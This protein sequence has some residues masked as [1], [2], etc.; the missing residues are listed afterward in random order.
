M[1]SPSSYFQATNVTASTNN[2]INALLC[3]TKWGG[4]LGSGVSM[5][6]SFNSNQSYY[7]QNY[8]A[9]REY[10]NAYLLNANQQN[11]VKAALQTWANVANLK[12]SQVTDSQAAA[13]DLRFAGYLG[14]TDANAWAYNPFEGAAGGDTWFSEDW[15]YDNDA[16]KGSYAYHTAIHEIGHALGLKHSFDVE[17]TGAT[18]PTST[19]STRYT[20]MSYTHPFDYSPTSPMLYDILA[21]QYLYGKNTSYNSGNTTYSWAAGSK[22]FET[23]WDGG[24]V[25]TISASNQTSAVK[26]N[27]NSGQNSTIGSMINADL[28]NDGYWDNQGVNDLLYIAYGTTIENAV[29]SGYNDTLIGNSV[30]NI[31]NGGGGND[32]MSGGYGNDTYYVNSNGDTV[33]ESAESSMG[34]I[35]TV[36][37][38]T[39][40]TLTLSTWTLGAYQENLIIT[41]AASF[42]GTGNGL[43]NKLTGN[44]S[45][46]I[47]K[48][49]AGND[50]LC[51]AAGNDSLYGGA[52]TDRF[53]LDSLTGYDR[54]ADFSSGSEKVICDN[55]SLGGI[56]D[57][58][59]TLEGIALRS[60]AGGFSKS[61]ELLIFSS[62]ISGSISQTTAAAKI[63]SA[64]S[65]YAVGDQRLFVVDNGT[66]TGLFLFKAGDADA[67]VESTELK[68][69]GLLNGQTGISDFLL[70]A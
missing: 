21:I 40:S 24:G 61:A 52:G 56:G 13:G 31:L 68:L 43:S 50:V 25:D 35:D 41:G 2:A 37:V 49:E 70:Q 3:G 46:N 22:I 69:L 17:F 44:S 42:N 59:A 5:T 38:S 58:D 30:A 62:N 45:N 1:P 4:A 14:M 20:V 57:K 18:L 23:I 8:S 28:N 9:D 53:I 34:G 48:G 60:S 11:N 51:G 27:L 39:G 29:G 63:G 33:I 16:A 7:T 36:V 54:I 32:T 12:F 26:L 65:A 6:Y 19:D 64:S 55:S 15:G 47:L 10:E 67:A 66:Q